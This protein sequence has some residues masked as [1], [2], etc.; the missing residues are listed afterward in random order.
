M[1]AGHGKDMSGAFDQRGREWLAPKVTDVHAFILANLHGVQT[2]RL[3][4]NGVH[5]SRGH[6]NIFSVSDQSAKETFR[7]GA[8]ANVTRTNKE[9]A[10]HDARRA[11]VRGNNLGSNKSKSTECLGR[12]EGDF[13]GEAIYGFQLCYGK[14][15]W[16]RALTW[17]D[18]RG[19][20][21]AEVDSGEDQPTRNRSPS[22]CLMVLFRRGMF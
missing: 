1:R 6:L 11:S 4:A 3:P 10:F 8:T 9:D 5:S 12:S 16:E 14:P 22:C 21:Y 15:R 7:D 17:L 20:S 18:G 2:G 19:F 13:T